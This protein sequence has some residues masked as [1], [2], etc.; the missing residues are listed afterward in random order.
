MVVYLSLV[1]S[2]HV[3]R[4]DSTIHSFRKSLRMQLEASAVDLVL[5]ARLNNATSMSIASMSAMQLEV[6]SVQM[7]ITDLMRSTYIRRGS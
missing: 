2:A 3:G 6:T 1:A 5:A 4:F 7:K